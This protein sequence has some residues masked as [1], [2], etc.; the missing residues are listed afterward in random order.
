VG[1]SGYSQKINE[2][3]QAYCDKIHPSAHESEYK[4]VLE[5]NIGNLQGVLVFVGYELCGG[6]NTKMIEQAALAIELFHAYLQCIDQG[7][8]TTQALRAQHEAEIILANLDADSENR[9]KALGITNRTLML[10]NLAR[11]ETTSEDDRIYWLA[12]EQALN[13]LHVGQVL[14]SADCKATNAVTPLAL[15]FGGDIA[16]GKKVDPTKFIEELRKITW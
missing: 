16:L 5:S 14:A 13:P 11:L 1:V 2:L 12:T 7:I 9:I 15:E 4:N 3:I 6:T 10:A 8:D